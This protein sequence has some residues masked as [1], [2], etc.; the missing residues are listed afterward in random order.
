MKRF[1]LNRKVDESGTSGRG[2]VLDG[3]LFDDGQVVVRWRKAREKGNGVANTAI[4]DTFEDFL[5]VHVNSHEEGSNL[6][7][8]VD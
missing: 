1:V 3:V 7:E 5:D 2:K 8:F 4:F 6:V